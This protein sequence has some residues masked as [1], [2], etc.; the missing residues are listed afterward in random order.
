M[1]QQVA[2]GVACCQLAIAFGERVV[3]EH[4]ARQA[5]RAA[6][7][8]GASL[9]VLPELANSGYTFASAE[10]TRELG[11]TPDG[12]TLRAWRDEAIGHHLVVVGGFCEKT[13]DGQSFNSAALIDA[14]G[15]IT[16]YRKAH[17]WARETI[18]FSPG[19]APAPIVETHLGRIGLGVCYDLEFP[20]VARGLA[21]GGADIICFPM[22]W[23]RTAPPAG[24]RSMA[25]TIAMATARLN[26]VFLAVCDRCGEERDSSF[27]G[28]SVIVNESGWLVDG[29]MPGGVAGMVFGECRLERAR[30]KR[31]NE[32]NDVLADRRPELYQCSLRQ[33]S[34]PED[35]S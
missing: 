34:S 26:R 4:L 30:D 31:V 8:K 27:E 2:V 17:L 35:H 7:A 5:I 21:L 15:R 28:T 9:V 13:R 23:P 6:A 32:W 33:S 19:E 25:V 29:P 22:N 12:P 1:Q 14:E 24:E 16:L 11:E 3:N 10:E 18:F 20:E